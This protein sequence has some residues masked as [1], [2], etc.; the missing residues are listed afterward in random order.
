MASVF[1]FCHLGWRTA[2]LLWLTSFPVQGHDQPQYPRDG[3]RSEFCKGSD[4]L[5]PE[6]RW[7]LL[8]RFGWA[9]KPVSCSCMKLDMGCVYELFCTCSY[10][11]MYVCIGMNGNHST[12]LSYLICMHV[13]RRACMYVSYVCPYVPHCRYIYVYIIHAYIYIYIYMFVY[14][15]V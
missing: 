6:P 1:L 14:E 13:C 8:Q 15:Y 5:D 2:L 3:L 4:R 9:Q 10:V 11:C 7:E 12:H